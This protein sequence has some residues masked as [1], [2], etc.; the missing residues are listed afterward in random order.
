MGHL[1]WSDSCLQKPQFIPRSILKILTWTFL[2]GLSSIFMTRTAQ[3]TR[4]MRLR[5]DL[6]ARKQRSYDAIPPTS[7]SLVHHVKRSAAKLP[8]YG[9]GILC[10]KCKLKALPT[11]GGKKMVRPGKFSGQSFLQLRRVAS[12]W[13]NVDARLTA[14]EDANAIALAST[15]H[16]YVP[17][18]V[19]T[20]N[21]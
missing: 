18:N 5:L 16:S 20:K 11:G 14:E 8:V 3:Q 13:Q 15:V 19:R 6:F 1:P 4:L 10:A 17:A 2:R 9:T 7:A 21:N 12:N